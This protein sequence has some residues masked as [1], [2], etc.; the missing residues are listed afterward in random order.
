LVREALSGCQL[1]DFVATPTEIGGWFGTGHRAVNEKQHAIK[2][3]GAPENRGTP[4]YSNICKE[5]DEKMQFDMGVT[6]LPLCCLP[7]W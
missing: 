5:V 3:E 1:S 6:R 7:H 4:S 2:T